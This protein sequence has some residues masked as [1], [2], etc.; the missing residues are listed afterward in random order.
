MLIIVM[1][2]PKLCAKVLQY[3]TLFLS[4]IIMRSM[5]NLRKN[6]RGQGTVGE[7]AD[8]GTSIRT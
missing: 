8:E 6:K 1:Y 2:C 4:S 3:N 5:S 7:W